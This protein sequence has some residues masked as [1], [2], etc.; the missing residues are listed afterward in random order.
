MKLFALLAL[1]VSLVLVGGCQKSEDAGSTPSTN[2]PA[3]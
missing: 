2:A 3:K 1:A